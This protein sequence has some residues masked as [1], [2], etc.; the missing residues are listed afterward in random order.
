MIV[1]DNPIPTSKLLLVDRQGLSDK[2]KNH[3]GIE[4]LTYWCL[5]LN[6]KP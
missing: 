1:G 6:P 2:Y 3:V 4:V 5:G